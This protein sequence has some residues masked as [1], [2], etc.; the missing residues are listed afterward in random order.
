MTR[1]LIDLRAYYRDLFEC[2]PAS[3]RLT[4]IRERTISRAERAA[5][6]RRNQLARKS[7][8]VNRRG[9]R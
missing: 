8:A 1:P 9:A 4:D 7:R 2:A 3:R 5:R 6:K